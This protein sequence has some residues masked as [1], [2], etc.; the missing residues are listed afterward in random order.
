MVNSLLGDM[1][2]MLDTLEKNAQDKKD[3]P[4][5]EYV[6]IMRKVFSKNPFEQAIGCRLE[7][8]HDREI[9]EMTDPRGYAYNDYNCSLHKMCHTLLRHE[10]YDISCFKSFLAYSTVVVLF[11]KK[12][13]PDMT[14]DKTYERRLGNKFAVVDRVFRFEDDGEE[15]TDILFHLKNAFAHGRV[16]GDGS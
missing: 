10:P 13:F 5:M 8:G 3:A 11:S 16:I 6:R 9:L 1:Q 7:E 4:G 15:R 2:L 12:T 14:H